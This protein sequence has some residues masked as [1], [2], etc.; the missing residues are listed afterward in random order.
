MGRES[1]IRC[2]RPT[3][4][5]ADQALRFSHSIWAPLLAERRPSGR[6]DRAVAILRELE[7]GGGSGR[8][9]PVDM[10][11]AYV[12]LDDLGSAFRWINKGIDERHFR[13][14]TWMHIPRSDQRLLDDPRWQQALSRLPEV[15]QV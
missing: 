2:R 8:L 1:R 5:L 14:V 3:R 4:F 9:D 6:V 10:I 11:S 12:A 13:V 7:T 15:P